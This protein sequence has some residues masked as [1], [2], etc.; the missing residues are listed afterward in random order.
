MKK[1]G[2]EPVAQKGNEKYIF[3]FDNGYGASVIWVD[4]A[5]LGFWELAVLDSNDEL[6][7]DT[8]VT[9]GVVRYLDDDQVAYYLNKIEH[10]SE[11]RSIVRKTVKFRGWKILCTGYES[12]G[13]SFWVTNQDS[14]VDGHDYYVHL[15]NSFSY[16][17]DDGSYYLPPFMTEEYL[18]GL[19]EQVRKEVDAKLTSVTREK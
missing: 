1:F 10:L 9:N 6:V 3:K 4:F 11:S 16:E 12:G 5:D 2:Y 18:I 19:A 7:Y 17:D 13:V 14:L 8:P 15:D